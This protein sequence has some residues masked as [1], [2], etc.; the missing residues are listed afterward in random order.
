[1]NSTFGKRLKSAR[2]SK[3]LTQK[4]LA[5]K[6]GAKHNSVSDW[7]NDKNKP[8]PD[9]IELLCGILEISP[10]YLLGSVSKDAFSPEE[11][12]LVKK[13]RVL[14]P[15]GKRIINMVLEE[16]YNRSVMESQ[17]NELPPHLMPVA[18]HNDNYS[19]EQQHLMQNDLDKLDKL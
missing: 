14:D 9:T 8:D 16:E 18:A 2:V 11:N 13:Y 3:K 17:R 6:I 19:D 15:H 7:E 4:E 5:L 10:N 12:E 1:M